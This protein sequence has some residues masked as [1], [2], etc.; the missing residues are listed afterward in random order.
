MPT[1]GANPLTH[2]MV[3]EIMHVVFLFLSDID[4]LL[5]INMHG[6]WCQSRPMCHKCCHRIGMT[7]HAIDALSFCWNK[8]DVFRYV[9]T[10]GCRRIHHNRYNCHHD[11]YY[12]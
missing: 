8:I 10:R 5:L 11:Y 9:H 4:F 6:V 12:A 2:S 1:C 3:A 7:I